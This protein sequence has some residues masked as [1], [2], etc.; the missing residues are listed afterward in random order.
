MRSEEFLALQG[1]SEFLFK[2]YFHAIRRHMC[3]ETGIVGVKFPISYQTILRDMYVE[4]RS[5]VLETGYPTKAKI[6]RGIAQLITCG[7][8]VPLKKGTLFFELTLARCDKTLQNKHKQA[9]TISIQQVDTQVDTR[10]RRENRNY[11]TTRISELLQADTEA[12]TPKT[13]QADKIYPLSVKNNFIK[14]GQICGKPPIRM[15]LFWKNEQ[16][17]TEHQSPLLKQK[18]K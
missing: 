3:F 17:K 6:Q 5:G 10:K 9:D 8:I 13:T 2:L 16:E 14:Q 1:K 4:P 11:S 15:N 12:D 18:L 7:L